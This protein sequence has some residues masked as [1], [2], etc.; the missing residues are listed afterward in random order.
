[1]D[2]NE[3]PNQTHNKNPTESPDIPLSRS[4]ASA[5]ESP[6]FPLN[7]SSTNA[8]ESP[9]VPLSQYFTSTSSVSPDFP[10]SRFS[11]TL[12]SAYDI[13][14]SRSATHTTESSP[15]ETLSRSVFPQAT[16]NQKS[17]SVLRQESRIKK[18][19]LCF[20]EGLLDSSGDDIDSLLRRSS[21]VHAP[22]AK[23]DYSF[24]LRTKGMKRTSRLKSTTKTESAEIFKVLHEKCCGDHHLSSCTFEIIQKGRKWFHAMDESD[25]TATLKTIIESGE[26]QTSSIN[27]RNGNRRKMLYSSGFNEVEGFCAKA[28]RRVLGVSQGKWDFAMSG[29]HTDERNNDLGSCSAKGDRSTSRIAEYVVRHIDATA[30]QF[31]EDM[32]DVEDIEIPSNF[33][34]KEIWRMLLAKHRFRI[35]ED[36]NAESLSDLTTL[37]SY[38]QFCKIWRVHLLSDC[39]IDFN[40]DTCFFRRKSCQMLKSLLTRSFLSAIHVSKLICARGGARQTGKEVRTCSDIH[41]DIQFNE[42]VFREADGVKDEA[43]HHVWQGARVSLEEKRKMPASPES[44][45]NS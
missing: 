20:D 12:T 35:G 16:P 38:C 9:D 26:M 7:R 33:T 43:S 4:F 31:G 5:S 23:R 28:M 14:P 32:P 18:R 25:K 34:K 2:H 27:F 40:C 11:S 21:S 24:R 8:S 1:M 17:A 15:D 30:K 3:S 13:P 41:Q 37:V 44:L 39:L 22:S 42:I 10:L 6:D 29:F 19:K 36:V 45:C